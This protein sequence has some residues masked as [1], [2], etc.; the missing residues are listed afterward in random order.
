MDA[1][2]VVIV[3]VVDVV[4]FCYSHCTTE[5]VMILY[6]DRMMEVDKVLYL[7]LL[8]YRTMEIGRYNVAAAN[9]DIVVEL[10]LLLLAA[11]NTVQWRSVRYC[12]L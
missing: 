9:S 1:A 10:P 11:R 5:I 7:K 12:I 4:A 2:T 8:Q 6:V 3:V